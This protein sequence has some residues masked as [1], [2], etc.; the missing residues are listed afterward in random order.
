MMKYP[1]QTLKLLSLVIKFKKKYERFNRLCLVKSQKEM[2]ESDNYFRSLYFQNAEKFVNNHD[3]KTIADEFL[4]EGTYM[5]S[6]QPLNKIS[7]FDFLRLCSALVIPAYEF[8]FLKNKLIDHFSDKILIDSVKSVKDKTIKTKSGRTFKGDNLIIATPPQVSKRLLGLEKIKSP[9]NS[10]V[11][12]VKGNL[13]EAS[14][15]FELFPSSSNVVFIRKQED[16]SFIFYSKTKNINLKK[17][18]E[19][20][21]IIAVKEWKPA[22]HMASNVLWDADIGNDVFLIGDHNL[23]GLEESFITGLYA[24]NKIISNSQK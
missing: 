18:F 13:K 6:F 9:V 14:G 2:I 22:F 12:H 21:K 23:I 19:K 20:P 17:Y 5:C 3:L 11:I 16:G 1:I 7:A 24:A 4:S 10:F 15:Q 8:E